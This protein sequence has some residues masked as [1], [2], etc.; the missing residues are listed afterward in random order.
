MMMKKR[1]FYILTSMV[2]L[3]A[4]FALTAVRHKE[5]ADY[6]ALV[7]EILD[8]KAAFDALL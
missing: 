3:V 8:K 2:L 7:K 1:L 4:M 6:P 5:E